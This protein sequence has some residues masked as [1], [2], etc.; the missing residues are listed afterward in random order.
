MPQ[1]ELKKRRHR[2]FDLT[3]LIDIVFNLLLFFLLTYQIGRESRIEVALPRSETAS[4]YAKNPEVTVRADGGI[5][6]GGRKLEAGELRAALA[7]AGPG[8]TVNI[9]ADEK[10][11][12]GAVVAVVDEIKSAGYGGFNIITVN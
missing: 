10:A 3:P 9:K 6:F 1:L 8:G 7:A 12:L 5:Y 4:A 2:H 11:D